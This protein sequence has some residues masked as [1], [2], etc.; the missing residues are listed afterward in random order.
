DLALCGSVV[1]RLL[2]HDVGR[3][4]PLD[5]RA[6]A[7]SAWVK[8]AYSPTVRR[9]GELLNFFPGQYPGGI[10]NAPSPVAAMLTSALVGGGL[11]YGTGWLAS[12]L[13]PCGYG[14]KLKRTG[15]VLGALLGSAPGALWM[16][17]Q[18]G[19]GKSHT[20]GLDLAAPP[21]SSNQAAVPDGGE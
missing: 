1:S 8:V 9:A 4:G 13:L 2:G 12:K 11:G 16:A 15:G 3:E 6:L 10:P 19:L 5:L 18:L 20:D 14:D 21:A 17:S 7:T